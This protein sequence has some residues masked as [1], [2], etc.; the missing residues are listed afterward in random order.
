[1]RNSVNPYVSLAATRCLERN[2]RFRRHRWGRSTRLWLKA[3]SEICAP[4]S[5]VASTLAAMRASQRW[6][7]PEDLPPSATC[8]RRTRLPLPSSHSGRGSLSAMVLLGV[9]LP[10]PSAAEVGGG[11]PLCAIVRPSLFIT[12]VICGAV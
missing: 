3:P 1:M 2:D 5:S 8:G 11:Q 4:A 9:R 12:A 10:M 6:T 7:G